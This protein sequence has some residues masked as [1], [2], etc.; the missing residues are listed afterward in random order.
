M[1]FSK[2]DGLC[3]FVTV[4]MP[5]LRRVRAI[6]LTRAVRYTAPNPTATAI[7]GE[8]NGQ[9]QRG[10][11]AFWPS[12]DACR[13]EP[14]EKRTTY[15]GNVHKTYPAVRSRNR[16]RRPSCLLRDKSGR[17]RVSR[18]DNFRALQMANGVAQRIRG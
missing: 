3:E 11:T 8:D 5:G 15:G 16:R 7:G 9:E 4:K 2:L 14:T 1:I 12:T 17:A 18:N 6:V 10:R 13:R